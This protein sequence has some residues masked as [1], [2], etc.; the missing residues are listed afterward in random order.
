MQLLDQLDESYDMQ[1]RVT[2]ELENTR[3]S[4]EAER[5]KI[6]ETDNA[7]K[8]NCSEITKLKIFAA[9]GYQLTPE[10]KVLVA[11][12][13]SDKELLGDRKQHASISKKEKNAHFQMAA[14]LQSSVE[15]SKRLDGEIATL[16]AQQEK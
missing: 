3:T 16:T 4:L 6:I 8:E 13:P 2:G 7:I 1:I 15:E 9:R 10:Q 5:K 14:D 12:S 11:N